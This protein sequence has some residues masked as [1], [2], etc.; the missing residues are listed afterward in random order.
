MPNATDYKGG[1]E[2]FLLI[3]QTGSGK[4]SLFTTLPG[5][6]FMYIFDPNA[7]NTIQG[8]DID[9]E[10][11]VP[12][13]MNKAVQSL[14]GKVVSDKPSEKVE[15][16]T[17]VEWEKDFEKKLS[18]CTLCGCNIAEES[19]KSDC[20]HHRFFD[21]YDVLGFDSITTFAELV[22][23]RVMYING[24]FGKQPM[25]DDWAAQ[26]NTLKNVFRETTALPLQF[27][28]TAHKDMKQ[29][30]LT[31]KMY[32][33]IILPGQLRVKLP[34]LFSEIYNCEVDMDEN[35]QSIYKIQTK[36]D[37]FHPVS[38]CTLGLPQFVDVTIPEG[39]E[40]RSKYG[41]G[42]ILREHKR[43]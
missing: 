11:F 40:D 25:Q 31:K 15:P 1:T 20:N 37:R 16:T 43:K 41:L 36:P 24:R 42:K 28:A 18:M 22:M 39:V 23:D 26:I 6:K 21:D 5:K 35:N 14:S 32:Y 38:R 34:L 3:G 27:F 12:D 33:H 10:L 17:Y 4:T 29:D 8:Q 13:A 2:K 30:E 7:L 19:T 9:Y